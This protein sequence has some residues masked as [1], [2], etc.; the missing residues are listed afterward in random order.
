MSSQI[1]SEEITGGCGVQRLTGL[2][3]RVPVFVAAF[4]R[5]R[6]ARLHPHS[7]ECGYFA[8]TSILVL[9]L[10]RRLDL[11]QR[12]G[13]GLTDGGLAV[14]SGVGQSGHG[15]LGLGADAAEGQ[16]G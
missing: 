11:L 14:A 9:F 15:S 12:I 8:R 3:S 10:R 1:Y 16:D 2:G 4:A 5:M 7:C 13:R 6:V